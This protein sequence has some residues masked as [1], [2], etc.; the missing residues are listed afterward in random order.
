MRE[1]VLKAHDQLKTTAARQGSAS[2]TADNVLRLK[3]VMENGA[4]KHASSNQSLVLYRIL[5][6]L[7]D[8]NDLNTFLDQL[9][10]SVA[11]E[12]RA[13]S[14]ALWLHDSRD[15]TNRLFETSYQGEILSGCAQLGHPYAA[16][17][18]LFKAKLISYV[19]RYGS[20]VIPR[21]AESPL[22]E[23][24]VSRWMATRGVESLLCVA[25][26]FGGESVGVM[27]I[28]GRHAGCFNRRKERLAQ[29]L[30]H[31]VSLALHLVRLA[32][33]AER[34]AV[35]QERSRM[36]EEI[37]DSLAQILVQ[38]VRQLDLIVNS[39]ETK[40]T[41]GYS[42][43]MRRRHLEHVQELA[44]E[45][46]TEA[47]RSVWA[48]CPAQLEERDLLGALKQLAA[49]QD[50]RAKVEFSLQGKPRSLPQEAQNNLFR[51]CQEALN[52]ALEHAGASKVRI[53]LAYER[54]A[55]GVKVEDDG[56]GFNVEQVG[57][58]GGFGLTSLRQRAE[59]VGGELAILSN[60][61]GG[62]R[63]VAKLPEA[64]SDGKGKVA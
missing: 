8:E 4:A 2:L 49:R 6:K 36:A 52:N 42:F 21:V 23:P 13:H 7:I 22:I 56:Q 9:L 57:G 46:L 26:T 44:R 5:A 34:S 48:L 58:H 29:L 14:V 3:K 27:T 38:I 37:H 55:V 60:P 64:A 51:I 24:Q 54:G 59:R 35:T 32:R 25:L 16:K 10:V 19:L 33:E 45:A 50:S 61:G 62:T 40:E 30:S 20:V 41:D 17:H 47:R 18:G 63:V 12:L 53:E 15:G 28:R 31:P 11:E 39:V 1:G 43:D